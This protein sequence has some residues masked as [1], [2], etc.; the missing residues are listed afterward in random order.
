VTPGRAPNGADV[1][2]AAGTWA[3]A[4]GLLLVAPL[5]E[6]ADGGTPIEVGHVGAPDWW[7]TV[8]TIC[9][10]AGAL[11][12]ARG[13]PRATLLVVCAIPLLA[14]SVV[15]EAAFSLT[16]L[17]VAVA[18]FR[19]GLTV[20]LRDSRLTVAAATVLVAAGDFINRT[21]V[22]HSSV[23][24]ASGL[25]APQTIAV[26]IAPLLLAFMFAAR[27]EAREAHRGE[28]RAVARERDALVAAAVARERAAMAR[29]LHDI[30]AHHLSGI[31]VMAAAVDRQIDTDPEAARRSVR[32]VRA[33]SK[34][35]LDDLR[36]LVGL[37][38]EEAGDERSAQTLAA[39]VDLVEDRRAAG[40]PVEVHTF[41]AQTG[42]PLGTGVGPLA[43]L[44]AYRMVQ[45]SLTN[46]AIHAQGAQCRVEIDDR[47]AA[48]LT[49][50]VTNAPAPAGGQ[51][52]LAQAEQGGFGLL[53]MQ[54][55]AGLV[56]AALRYGSTADRGWL[57]VLTI[58]RDDPIETASDGAAGA[59][60]AT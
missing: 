56:G 52:V 54:E 19:A 23:L 27:R 38:R 21:V 46:A 6:A 58:P 11:L 24:G 25:A 39:V 26:V 57:V 48:T 15:G 20:P 53:G 18:V 4:C 41:T 10:Q 17:A 29:E 55:R 8:L 37:L 34:T 60:V 50:T 45:E 40:L 22:G 13:A 7:L 43:Q 2:I 47:D 3:C 16:R 1:A 59:E 12:W 30:A 42:S 9:L 49:V 36:R 51:A 44:V 28:L 32:E 14:A 31:A 35:V 33:Q 5:L